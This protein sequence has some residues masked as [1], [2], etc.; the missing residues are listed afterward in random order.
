MEKIT[1]E[2]EGESIEQKQVTYASVVTLGN[3]L[4][5]ATFSKDL[6]QNIFQPPTQMIRPILKSSEFKQS[7]QKISPSNKN[8]EGHKDEQKKK[9]FT[10]HGQ[11]YCVSP[12]P[13]PKPSPFEREKWAERVCFCFLT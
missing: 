7:D 8:R 10:T 9:N 3:I 5:C 6:A 11:H 1:Q 13:P 12:S 4:E 2:K